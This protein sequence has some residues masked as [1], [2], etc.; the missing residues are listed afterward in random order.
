MGQVHLREATVI[1]E[2]LIM[3]EAPELGLEGS[4]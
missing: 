4:E 1:R 3:E 2:G